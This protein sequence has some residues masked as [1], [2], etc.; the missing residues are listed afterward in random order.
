LTGLFF[1]LF[2]SRHF[3]DPA[4]GLFLAS[5]DVMLLMMC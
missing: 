5:D 2:Q 4:V 1:T 3:I